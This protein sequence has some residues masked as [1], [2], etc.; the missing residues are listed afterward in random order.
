MIRSLAA[1]AA[2]ALALTACDGGST[3]GD[4]AQAPKRVNQYQ[5]KL[6]ALEARDR[7]LALRRAVQDDGGSCP[8]VSAAS[9]QQEHL[10][11]AMW[12]VRCEG[13]FG[14]RDWAVFVGASG[15]V[16]ARD[17]RTARQAGLPECR[18]PQA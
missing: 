17:C 16:Q 11:M 5:Q 7:N 13:R 14:P 3:G 2:L 1:T 8:R 10:K 9:Y 15:T 6:L 18:A 4:A 12:V